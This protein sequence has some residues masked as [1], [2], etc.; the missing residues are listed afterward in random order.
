[1]R[2]ISGRL[3]SRRL[4]APRG[5]GTRPTHDRV[6]EALFSMLGNLSGYNVADLYAGTGALGIEALSRG[7]RHACFVERNRAAL[8][9]LRSNI[10]ELALLDQ[11]TIIARSLESAQP[12]LMQQAPFD[13]VFCDP[14]WP[15]MDDALAVLSRL[16]P[17]RWLGDDG[18]LVL[19]HPARFDP[20]D[21]AILGLEKASQ[22]SWGD[23][24]VTLFGVATD[25][26]VTDTSVTNAVTD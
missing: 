22:R 8:E 1:M 9:C 12:D 16:E 7:A 2:V 10:Q 18:V 6:K 5:Q 14:P 21:H 25:T 15:Q 20:P 23:T 13:V 24:A 3:R 4:H 19:E 11:T 17:A 26:S